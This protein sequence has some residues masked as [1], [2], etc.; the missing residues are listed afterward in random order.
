MEFLELVKLRRSIR[1]YHN[2]AIEKK[3]LEYVLEAGRQAPSAVNFQ[4]WHFL[5]IKN[6]GLLKKVKATYGKKWI[7]S[8]PMVLVICG[9]H[10]QS[11][12]RGDGKDHCNID[13]AIAIDHITLAAAEQGLGT[14]WVCKFNVMDCSELLKLPSHIE[15]VALLPIGYPAENGNP[16]RHNKRKK[17]D[18]I[19]QWNGFKSVDKK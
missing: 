13:V 11:W 9:D 5:V 18:E 3:K 8:A 2:K 15:P 10:S 6:T 1:K 4:P 17:M 19:V 7:D 16:K 14:C 12:R